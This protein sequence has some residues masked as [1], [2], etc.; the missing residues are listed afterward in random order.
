MPETAQMVCGAPN[1]ITGRTCIA[2][3]R[4]VHHRDADGRQ[5]PNSPADTEAMSPAEAVDEIYFW[6]DPRLTVSDRER[7]FDDL[8]GWV[9]GQAQVDR[10][11]AETLRRIRERA[12]R[13]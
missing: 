10:F 9:A 3:I 13:S 8:I 5:W 2:R 12:E 7:A 4:H 11:A 1:P 6:H